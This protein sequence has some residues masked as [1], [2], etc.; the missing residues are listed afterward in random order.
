MADIR[1]VTTVIDDLAR[2]DELYPPGILPPWY[3][4]PA[5]DLPVELDGGL[6]DSPSF[7]PNNQAMSSW[8]GGEMRGDRQEGWAQ[9]VADAPLHDAW[10]WG[11]LDADGN[12]YYVRNP[13]NVL[14]EP[15]ILI[16]LDGGGTSGT[17]LDDSGG[18][19]FLLT[20][21]APDIAII[22]IDGSTVQAGYSQDGG[23]N[24]TILVSATDTTYREGLYISFGMQ[25]GGP[26]WESIGGGPFIRRSQIYRRLRN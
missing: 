13:H 16:R 14:D 17:T 8:R 6:L 10:Y 15:W 26:N 18:I 21:F 19:D 20:G 5:W 3:H 4:T 9:A 2:A 23:A 7:D 12:G 24:W 25:G 1:Y 22:Q 11:L